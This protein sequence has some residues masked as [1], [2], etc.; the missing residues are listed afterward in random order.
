MDSSNL[1]IWVVAIWGAVAIWWVS[2]RTRQEK[3]PL[4]AYV[5][6][7]LF[8]NSKK[9]DRCRYKAILE[10][11]DVTIDVAGQD[12]DSATGFGVRGHLDWEDKFRLGGAIR[13]RLRREPYFWHRVYLEGRDPHSS[14]G[15]GS[16]K[17]AWHNSSPKAIYEEL[18]ET[19]K[20]EESIDAKVQVAAPRA[21][22]KFDVKQSPRQLAPRST[23]ITE[24]SPVDSPVKNSAEV[25]KTEKKVRRSRK[26]K[27]FLVE[28][29][30]VSEG[31]FD[32]ERIKLQPTQKATVVEWYTASGHRAW[33]GQMCAT[34]L[35]N[36]EEFFFEAGCGGEIELLVEAG[37]TLHAG[38]ALCRY[39]KND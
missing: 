34:L 31:R 30:L 2:Y 25:T 24:K 5:H 35:I 9:D 1:V 23:G 39:R 26:E 11:L 13:S 15:Y 21:G 36:E 28:T 33:R 4:S 29:E 27:E 22:P 18:L 7:V 16:I 32:I 6:V 3:A 17:T 19:S 8:S 12:F 37:R 38:Q 20:P 14:R 10:G